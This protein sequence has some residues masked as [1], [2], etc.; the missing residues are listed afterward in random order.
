LISLVIDKWSWHR[1]IALNIMTIVGSESNRMILGILIATAGISMFV[2]NAA[3]ALMMLPVAVALI[4]EV[5]D[6]QI[7]EGENF[8]KFSKGI[9]LTIA[10]YAT[11]ESLTTL[12]ASVPT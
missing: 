2:S 4:N 7:L 11:I 6:K 3:T 9:L 8:K 12:V 1:R 10:Y 5:Q